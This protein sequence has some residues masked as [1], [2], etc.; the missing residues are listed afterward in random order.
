VHGLRSGAVRQRIDG[1]M[2][3]VRI[4]AASSICRTDQLLPSV[5][6][7]SIFAHQQHN[8]VLGLRDRPVSG[9]P[10]TD[11]LYLL[12]CWQRHQYDDK[13]ERH[14]MHSVCSWSVQQHIDSDVC[15]VCSRLRHQYTG[16]CGSNELHGVCGGSVQQRIDNRVHDMS[17]RLRHGYTGRCWSNQLHCV[18]GGSVQQHIDSRVHDMSRWLSHGYTGKCWSNQLRGVCGGSVQQRIDSR[19]HDMSRWLRH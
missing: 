1:A 7:W 11:Q 5:P 13:F 3:I 12:Q 18:C 9:H 17:R 14:D 16:R 15:R 19:V 8:N 2:C 4:W 6:A 10:W